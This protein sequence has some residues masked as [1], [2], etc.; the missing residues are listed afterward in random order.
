VVLTVSG[1]PLAIGTIISLS[2]NSVC[3][4]DW[5]VGYTR[6]KNLITIPTMDS[7][8]HHHFEAVKA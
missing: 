7:L 6:E 5:P 1:Y 2:A 3:K 8:I 4:S